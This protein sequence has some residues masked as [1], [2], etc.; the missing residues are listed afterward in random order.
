MRRFENEFHLTMG[1]VIIWMGF[2][3]HF[4]V[5][6]RLRRLETLRWRK[7]AP[8]SSRAVSTLSVFFGFSF[9]TRRKHK[10]QSARTMRIPINIGME[11]SASS[12]PSVVGWVVVVVV[13]RI[14]GLHI[15]ASNV[16]CIASFIG[17]QKGWMTGR[18]MNPN[19]RSSGARNDAHF[20]SMTHSSKHCT[21]LSHSV[22]VAWQGSVGGVQNTPVMTFFTTGCVGASVYFFYALVTS[23]IKTHRGCISVRNS[24]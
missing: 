23:S 18:T 2:H 20:A 11:S 15:T 13:G 9:W 19:M 3:S 5:L 10:Q 21:T 24:V 7:R 1:N 4:R 8:S 16:S 12:F 22:P 17:P 6:R 14:P